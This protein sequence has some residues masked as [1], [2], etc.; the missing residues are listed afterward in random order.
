MPGAINVHYAS[1]LTPDGT[2]KSADT[3]RLLFAEKKI[4]FSR[5]IVTTCGSGITA[6][7]AMLALNVA[8]AHEVSLYDGSWSEWGARPE[9]PV[10]TE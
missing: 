1:L 2:L 3:L 8:G 7:I 9:A 4:D 5:A 10:V 6:A